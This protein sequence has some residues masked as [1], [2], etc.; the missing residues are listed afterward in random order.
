MDRRCFGV[1]QKRKFQLGPQFH[2]RLPWNVGF[3]L[4]LWLQKMSQLTLGK[5][6]RQS[7]KDMKE[8]RGSLVCLEF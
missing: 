4:S 5:E 8:G 3:W 7:S 6:G 2:R 1:V